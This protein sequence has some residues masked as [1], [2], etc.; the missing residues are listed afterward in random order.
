MLGAPVAA[1]DFAAAVERARD[2][3]VDALLSA[4]AAKGVR[5]VWLSAALCRQDICPASIDGVFLYRDAGHLS[6]EGSRWIGE[7]TAA[8]RLP[9]P[10]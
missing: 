1:C 10:P 4:V 6:F 7:H 8:L 2:A 9:A 3:G 5:V